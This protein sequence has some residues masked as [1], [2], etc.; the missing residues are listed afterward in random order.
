M[1]TKKK[2][3]T[4]SH[5]QARVA[6]PGK[7]CAMPQL[8]ERQFAPGVTPGRAS[9]IVTSA[10]KWVNGTRLHYCFLRTP[11]GFKGSDAHL[12]KVREAFD[13]WKKLGIGLSFQEVDEASEAEIRIGF[14]SGDGHWSYIGRDVLGYGAHERTMNLDKADSW[15][16][17]TAIHEIGHS[18]GLPHEHQNPNAGIVWDE[19]A[20]YA[21]LAGP[22]N[23]WS[24]AKTFHNI[25]RKINPDTVQ[26]SSWDP[27]SVMHYPFEPGLI[28]EPLKYRNGLNPKGGLSPRDRE[29]IRVFYPPLDDGKLKRLR[30]FRSERLTLQPTQQVDFA[31]EPE[32]TRSYTVATFGQSDAVL[33]LFEDVDGAPR[34]VT[35]DDDSGEDC[36]ASIQV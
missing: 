35:G 36:N 29:W 14:L 3:N 22:P 17:D 1:A 7:F 8:P 13:A 30:P 31:I 10:K 27:D 5:K 20:V 24:R 4:A 19:E 12:D 34:Y 23:H 16:L 11:A 9:L 26:G 6:K 28:N 33:V 25:I 2:R 21:A 18:L 32:D 15:G